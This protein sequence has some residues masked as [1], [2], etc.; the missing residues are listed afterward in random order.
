MGQESG[1]EQ[2][3]YIS[4][5][6]DR[7]S[8]TTLTYDEKMKLSPLKV[9]SISQTNTDGFI[10]YI[11]YYPRGIMDQLKQD[12]NTEIHYRIVYM[13][14]TYFVDID[15]RHS[16]S[17]SF[18][19]YDYT[20]TQN[21]NLTY[22]TSLFN[23]W[24]TVISN[25]TAIKAKINDKLRPKYSIKNCINGVFDA[26]FG[27][28]FLSSNDI[29][30]IYNDKN[31][32]NL[33]LSI[34]K[35]KDKDIPEFNNLGIELSL[36][37]DYLSK[38][39]GFLPERVYFNG[40]INK[41]DN[42][43][44]IYSLSTNEEKLYIILE[45]SSLSDKIEFVLTSDEKSYKNDDFSEFN[46]EKYNG[47]YIQII[48]LDDYFFTLEKKLFLKIFT[49]EEN[50]YEKIDTY[51]FKYY[52]AKD[53]LSPYIKPFS[54]E[55]QSKLKIRK[56]KNKNDTYI[57]K[58]YPLKYNDVSYYIKAVYKKGMVYEENID[59]I[60][61][62]E[63]PG[64]YI[65]INNP[66]YNNKDQIIFELNVSQEISY[67]K[68]MAK[69]NQEAQKYFYL[70]KPFDIEK[71]P[72]DNDDDDNNNKPSDN[73]DSKKDDS[74]LIIGLSVG[75]VLVV[76]V[77]ILVVFIILYHRKNKDLLNQVNK[78]SFAES[79]VK[80]KVDSNLLIND[81]NELD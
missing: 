42:K 47:R 46:I 61:I 53:K 37:S 36:H 68:I 49:K 20:L 30:K 33:F 74:T 70:Y 3:Y 56:D 52:S 4:G 62:S 10:F 48:K 26:A 60:A 64:K 17:I 12:R 2:K 18:N 24:A 65:Q 13:P 27:T 50:L 78:I 7:L 76:I 54:E 45:Y 9:Q 44:L 80:E 23:I 16:Y 51:I 29:K 15:Q 55:S 31:T 35:E 1:K 81:E 69:V 73:K 32:P 79:G 75:G 67:I 8:L 21:Q 66:E 41:A 71:D 58:L 14:L 59:S 19:F 77:I 38:G 28:L 25:E 22:D 40:K 43:T 63:S 39:N 6:N 11:T 34:D 5:E 57:I 72:F